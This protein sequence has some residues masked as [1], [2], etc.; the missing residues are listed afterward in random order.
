MIAAVVSVM[1]LSSDSNSPNS[2]CLN[3]GR[4][5]AKALASFSQDPAAAIPAE[6]RPLERAREVINLG[7]F[8]LV[9]VVE[10]LRAIFDRQLAGFCAGLVGKT[11]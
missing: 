6:D 5:R 8:R 7:A 9:L 10:I 1:Q 3:R 2:I 11:P 4:R